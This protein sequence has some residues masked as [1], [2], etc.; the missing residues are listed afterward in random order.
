[1]GT[2]HGAV[3]MESKNKE[4]LESRLRSQGVLAGKAN[5]NICGAGYFGLATFVAGNWLVTLPAPS[6]SKLVFE[7]GEPTFEL[8]LCTGA[9]VGVQEITARLG[10]L[11]CRNVAIACLDAAELAVT[12]G[13]QTRSG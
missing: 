3:P 9:F 6:I 1:M 2:A 5:S 10:W 12:R 8:P 11:A 7:L 13:P 4:T